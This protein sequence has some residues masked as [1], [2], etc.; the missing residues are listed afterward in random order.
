MGG[1]RQCSVILNVLKE[2]N[3]QPK[4]LRYNRYNK[5]IS[6]KLQLT[7]FLVKE[8]SKHAFQAGGKRL[9]MESLRYKKELGAKEVENMWANLTNIN[10]I[11]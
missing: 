1:R 3:Y 11:K 2:N 4:I 6:D 10:C 9:H 5:D 8:I 7:N